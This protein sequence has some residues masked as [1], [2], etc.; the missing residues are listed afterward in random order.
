MENIENYLNQL[1]VKER[2]ALKERIYQKDILEIQ[3]TQEK[4]DIRINKLE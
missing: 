4:H 2:N 1:S 3:N